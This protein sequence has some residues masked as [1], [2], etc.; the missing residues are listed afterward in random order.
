MD[1]RH[2]FLWMQN[3][4]ENSLIPYRLLPPSW[5]ALERQCGGSFAAHQ[6]AFLHVMVYTRPDLMYPLNRGGFF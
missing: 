5:A 4:S 1:L 3:L 6:G 2:H